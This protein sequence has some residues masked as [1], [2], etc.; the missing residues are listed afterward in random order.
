[1]TFEPKQNGCR[2]S[3]DSELTGISNGLS[4]VFE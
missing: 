3:E 1:M 2:E 4:V